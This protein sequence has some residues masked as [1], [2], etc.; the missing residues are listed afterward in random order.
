[1]RCALL[2]ALLIEVGCSPSAGV[3]PVDGAGLPADP[4]PVDLGAGYGTGEYIVPADTTLTPFL[5][6]DP[7][8]R[9]DAA[10]MALAD[11][12]DYLPSWRP[13]WGGS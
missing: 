12:R 2:L 6:D 3:M 11:G 9:F 1:M 10:G 13:T 5:S 8:R 7:M 4:A